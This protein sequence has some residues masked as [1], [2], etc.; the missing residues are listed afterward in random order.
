[1]TLVGR[2]E[3]LQLGDISSS[4]RVHFAHVLRLQES[5]IKSLIG[6]ARIVDVASDSDAEMMA[7]LQNH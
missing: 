5:V 1:M 2:K 6:E 4:D 3:K 7:K